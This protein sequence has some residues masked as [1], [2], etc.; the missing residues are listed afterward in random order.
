MGVL[1][2]NM[3]EKIK[4]PKAYLSKRWKYKQPLQLHDYY[5]LKDGKNIVFV[6]QPTLLNRLFT[7]CWILVAF[8]IL[9]ICFLFYGW[10]QLF[11]YILDH[12]YRPKWYAQLNKKYKSYD[13]VTEE[14]YNEIMTEMKEV[15]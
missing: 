15:K 4:I 14:Y 1:G 13:E 10:G 9:L 11:G 5:F 12:F 2:G 8:P 6:E 3:I 7:T